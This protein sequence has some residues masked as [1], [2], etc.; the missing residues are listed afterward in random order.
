MFII[1]SSFK[2]PNLEFSNAVESRLEQKKTSPYNFV[3]IQIESIFG[4]CNQGWQYGT[5]RRYG[6]V[7]LNFCKEVRYAFFVMV[8]VRYVGTVRLFLMVSVRYA[9]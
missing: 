3:L 4:A 1:S 7:R 5:A 9:V 8:R 2:T 6:T